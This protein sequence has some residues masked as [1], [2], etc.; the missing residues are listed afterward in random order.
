MILY[1]YKNICSSDSESRRLLVRIARWDVYPEKLAEYKD[2][3]YSE[4][5]YDL[6]LRCFK[7][8]GVTRTSREQLL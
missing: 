1:V 4:F 8:N 2:R 3:L 5:S 7:D 6:V